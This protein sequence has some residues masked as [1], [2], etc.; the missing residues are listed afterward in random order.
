MNLMLTVIFLCVVVGLLS[1]HFGRRQQIAIAV[2]ATAMT[3][4]YY[5]RGD[6]FM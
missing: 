4:L 2:I 1:P 5:L 6:R 3:T